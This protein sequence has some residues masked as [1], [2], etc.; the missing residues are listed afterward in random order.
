MAGSHPQGLRCQVGACEPCCERPWGV[1]ED[2]LPSRSGHSRPHLPWYPGA[3]TAPW[4]PPP[5]SGCPRAPELVQWGPR[6]ILQWLM[7]K[8]RAPG[9]A[10]ESGSPETATPSVCFS[11]KANCRL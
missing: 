11:F 1:T 9:Q 8:H 5:S 2:P 7:G 10:A 3:C 6:G 4:G